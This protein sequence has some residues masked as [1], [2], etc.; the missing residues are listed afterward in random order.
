MFNDL[1]VGDLH[2]PLTGRAWDGRTVRDQCL[3][4]MAHYADL[5]LRRFDR[6]FLHHGNTLEFFADLLAIWRLGGC[7]VPIDSRLTP[8]EVETLAGAAT[9]RFSIW[10]ESPDS[11]LAARLTSLGAR[12]LGA[13]EVDERR[14]HT[15]SA[16][17]TELPALDDDALILFTSGTTGQPKGVVHTH[18]SLRAR[19]MALRDHLGLEALHTHAVHAPHALRPWAHLQLPVPVAVGM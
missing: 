13:Q 12:V 16:P 17:A 6:V 1:S 18:R 14:V 8:F 10:R 15:G 9:P 4:R 7:A 19:W 5:G 11:A 2:E 3:R